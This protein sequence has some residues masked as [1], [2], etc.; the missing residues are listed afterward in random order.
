MAIQLHQLGMGCPTL[1]VES[2][3]RVLRRIGAD[4]YIHA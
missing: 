4:R 3:K 2:P 1:G